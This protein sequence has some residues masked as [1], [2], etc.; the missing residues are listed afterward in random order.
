MVLSGRYAESVVVPA[1]ALARI[2]D[3]LDAGEAAPMGC[4]GVATFQRAR[5]SNARPGDLVAVVGIGGPG[6]LG[7]PFA[8]R[9]GFEPV[10]VGR[11]PEMEATATELGAHHYVELARRYLAGEM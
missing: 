7:V 8:A 5:S 2:P 9:M 4:A 6:H 1:N 3:A 10:A 11:G